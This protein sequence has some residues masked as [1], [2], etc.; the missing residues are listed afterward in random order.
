MKSTYNWLFHFND[1]KGVWCAVKRE[2]AG[3]LFND[4]ENPKILKSPNVNAILEI[5]NKS[6][7]DYSKI[8][9]LL[10]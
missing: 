2:D 5:I 3:L 4:V 7:G 6:G 1:Y 10:K 9:K 8:K